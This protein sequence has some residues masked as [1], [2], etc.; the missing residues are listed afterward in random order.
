MIERYDMFFFHL[1]YAQGLPRSPNQL[2]DVCC[3]H[4][5]AGQ[6]LRARF[7]KDHVSYHK[8]CI[9]IYIYSRRKSLHNLEIEKKY[10]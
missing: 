9:C 6:G 5:A 2:K 7:L 3:Q 10:S 8:R 1:K 4:L